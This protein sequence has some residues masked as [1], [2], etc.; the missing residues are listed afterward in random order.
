FCTLAEALGQVQAVGQ[1]TVVL[2]AAPPY[3]KNAV[4]ADMQVAILSADGE[5]APRLQGDGGAA[6]RVEPGAT[7]Y[8]DGIVISRGSANGL[9]VLGTVYADDVEVS[10][11]S[12]IGVLVQ[13]SG[14]FE[15][16]RS[17]IVSN[18]QGGIL[19]QSQPDDSG[20]SDG[21]DSGTSASTGVLAGS[22]GDFE[23]DGG[24]P[25]D[26]RQAGSGTPSLY[27]ENCFVSGGNDDTDLVD[28]ASGQAHILYSTLAA[29]FGQASVIA[30]ADSSTVSVRNS[31]LATRHDTLLSCAVEPVSSFTAAN[32]NLPAW[33]ADFNAGDLTLTTPPP[34]LLTAARWQPG[35]PTTDI[36]GDRRPAGPDNQD[37]AGAD[38]PS[39]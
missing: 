23:G 30:C 28:V 7:V 15:A 35:D 24:L 34:A 11:N 22:S 25:F 8:L 26:A 2:H 33:F 36:N 9:E 21:N 3:I 10:Q 31:V 20:D 38:V 17:R 37:V 1:G 5:A 39:M 18:A 32:A 13:A 29:R 27:L 12:G 4:I 19:L 16:R 6:L 14:R